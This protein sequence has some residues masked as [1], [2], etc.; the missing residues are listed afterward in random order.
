[1]PIGSVTRGTTG[2]NRLR[3]VDRFIGQLPGF[4]ASPAPLVVDLGFGAS[5]TTA[6]ELH[7]RLSLL[8]AGVEVVG[9]EIEPARVARAALSA[10]PGVSFRLGGF[11]VP[12]DRGRR[13]TVIRA[14]NVLRQYGEAD[15]L[16]HWRRMVDRLEPGGALIEGTCSESG[17]VA[18]WVTLSPDGPMSLTMSL[19]LPDLELPSIVA[20]RLPKAL[21]HRNVPGERVHELMSDLDRYWRLHAGLGIWS[22]RQRWIATVRSI[23]AEGWPVL[24]ARTRSR[25]GELTIMWAALAPTGFA[26]GP[27]D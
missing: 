1:M 3:R 24:G 14:F 15:V 7:D 9:I 22:S 4:L 11:E 12:L 13:A 6:L 16:G 5:P 23:A 8:R 25:L 2:T 19:R 21:I 17:R 20:E 27:R 10:R 26:W 18:S